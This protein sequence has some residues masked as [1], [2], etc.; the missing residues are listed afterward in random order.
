[1]NG[2]AKEWLA[3]QRKQG[4]KGIEVKEIG[5]NHYVYHST[6]YWDKQL[7][8]RRK[9]SEY[10]GKLDRTAGLIEGLKRSITATNLRGIKEYCYAVKIYNIDYSRQRDKGLF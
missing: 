8:K 5:N 7:K 6:T 3:E 4:K 9:I 10:I 2:W 1:M